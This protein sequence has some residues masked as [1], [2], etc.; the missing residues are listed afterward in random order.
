MIARCAFLFPLLT[1]LSSDQVAP[2]SRRAVDMA[3]IEQL[4]SATAQLRT[5]GDVTTLAGPWTDDVVALP[6]DRHRG[7]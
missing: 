1:G 2:G 4:P 5:N 3:A 6:G 7:Y